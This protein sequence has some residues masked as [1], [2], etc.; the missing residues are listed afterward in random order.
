MNFVPSVSEVDLRISTSSVILHFQNSV[1]FC[2]LNQLLALQNI[3]KLNSSFLIYS[4]LV[5]YCRI[6]RI[7]RELEE[8]KENKLLDEVLNLKQKSELQVAN[9]FYE[10]TVFYL[11]Q[12]LLIPVKYMFRLEKQDITEAAVP[13]KISVLKNFVI[14]TGKHLC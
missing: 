9:F 4:L 1:L 14:F 11:T 2:I 10:Q 6:F 5:G 13:F 7:N 12:A 8:I 3:W